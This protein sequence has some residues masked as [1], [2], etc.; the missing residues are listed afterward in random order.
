MPGGNYIVF[1]NLRP[2]VCI[3]EHAGSPLR[4]RRAEKVFKIA[5][6]GLVDSSGI[7]ITKNLIVK[8]FTDDGRLVD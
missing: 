4:G 7:K 2:P 1:Q 3:D 8:N 6:K 5:K